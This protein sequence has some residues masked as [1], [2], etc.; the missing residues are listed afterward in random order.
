[1]TVW[2]WVAV[3]G[4]GGAGAIGRFVVDTLVA[5]RGGRDF[6]LGTLTINLTGTLLLGLL[7]RAGAN[8]NLYLLAGTATLGSY[9]TFSTWMLE[10]YRL[11]ED[12]ESRPALVNAIVSMLLGFGAALLGRAIG[13]AL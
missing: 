13:V 9:T 12:A 2:L 8:G 10:T 7:I 3:A 6:P 11:T 4:V 1:M 5:A